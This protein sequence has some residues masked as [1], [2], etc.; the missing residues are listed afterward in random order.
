MMFSNFAAISSVY[1]SA[2]ATL[3][4]LTY[5]QIMV[6]LLTLAL[7]GKLGL[8]PITPIVTWLIW[9]IIPRTSKPKVEDD[10]KSEKPKKET[11][12]KFWSIYYH[13]GLRGDWR[14]FFT[15]NKTMIPQILIETIVRL[16][17]TSTFSTVTRSMSELST[18]G[19]VDIQMPYLY[20]LMALM[21]FNMDINNLLNF[22]FHSSKVAYRNLVIS[23]ITRDGAIRT[24]SSSISVLVKNDAGKFYSALPSYSFCFED[25]TDNIGNLIIQFLRTMVFSYYILWEEP[26]TLLPFLVAYNIIVKKLI[27]LIMYDPQ[28]RTLRDFWTVL[29][30]TINEDH[31]KAYNPATVG[32]VFQNNISHTESFLELSGKYSFLIEKMGRY[33]HVLS[34]IKGV[35]VFGMV[36]FSCQIG[37]YD[38]ALLILMSG[39]AVFDVVDMWVNCQQ[40]QSKA[41]RSMDKMID[42]LDDI[43]QNKKSSKDPIDP[44]NSFK[45]ETDSNFSG[46]HTISFASMKV[47]LDPDTETMG[48][49]ESEMKKDDDDQKEDNLVIHIPTNSIDIYKRGITLLDGP[50]GCGKTS[51]LSAL[52]G[53]CDESSSLCETQDLRIAFGD[54]E[55]RTDFTTIRCHRYLVL[56]FVTELYLH[57]GAIDCKLS[58]LFPGAETIEQVRVFLADVFKMKPKTI[59]KSLDDKPPKTLSGGERQR[60]VL[61]IQFWMIMEIMK[62]RR[63]IILLDEPFRNIDVETAQHIMKW[64][65]AHIDAYFIMVTHIAEIK[66]LIRGSDVLDQVWHFEMT[67]DDP[68]NVHVTIE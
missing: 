61:A 46:I 9:P 38:L 22:L 56:Q 64:I 25:I 29:Y 44:R 4:S 54:G 51:V 27:P 40:I 66:A 53:M 32:P 24:Y 59:P 39:R 45:Y 3:F 12:W 2:C 57:N 6:S 68:E 19:A 1:I 15:E 10:A 65:L 62:T 26:R 58:K 18:N 23:R 52:A 17:M 20:A 42:I 31:T 47:K 5:S 50:S 37:G 43:D 34:F 60:Y 14:S 7:V 21:I 11:R 33:R 35:I 30:Y 36:F 48:A 55:I 63:L 41:E 49:G 8:D 67:D 13:I 16:V 28:F